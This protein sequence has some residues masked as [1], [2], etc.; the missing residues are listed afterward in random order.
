MF[1]SHGRTLIDGTL[2]G[3]TALSHADLGLSS[4]GTLNTAVGVDSVAVGNAQLGA[5]SVGSLHGGSSDL[6]L[7]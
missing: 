5:L 3:G 4:G 1:L 6:L 7:G 2:G